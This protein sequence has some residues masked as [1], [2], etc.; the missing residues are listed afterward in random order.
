MN[1]KYP[2]RTIECIEQGC[3]QFV[4]TRARQNKVLCPECRI[5]RE[6]LKERNR[7]RKKREHLSVA[8]RVAYVV[9]NDPGEFPLEPGKQLNH[10]EV[11]F[12]LRYG[13]FTPGT[14]LKQANNTFVVAGTWEGKQKLNTLE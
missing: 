5:K 10:A 9:S 1:D 12:G 7:Q 4:T 14:V 8:P 11:I 6:K 2:Q 13:T 3:N